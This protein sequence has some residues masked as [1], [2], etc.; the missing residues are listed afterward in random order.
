MCGLWYEVCGEVNS[1]FSIL[2]DVFG[3]D[4]MLCVFGKVLSVA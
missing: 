3:R 4:A 2:N 1:Q